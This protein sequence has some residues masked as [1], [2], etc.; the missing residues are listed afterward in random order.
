MIIAIHK[1]DIR[2]NY[3]QENEHKLLRFHS[4]HMDS[5]H[6]ALMLPLSKTS[7]YVYL[8]NMMHTQTINLLMS[9]WSLFRMLE[10]MSQ[11]FPEE[12]GSRIRLDLGS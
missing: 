4:V 8:L 5:S 6:L 2:V 9:C 12:A 11:R 10:D 1:N 3:H 7:K